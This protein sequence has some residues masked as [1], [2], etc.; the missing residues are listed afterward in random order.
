MDNNDDPKTIMKIIRRLLKVPALPLTLALVLPAP[1][2][3]L[4]QPVDNT[5][6]PE[7]IDRHGQEVLSKL[8]E[9]RFDS[10][11]YSGMP[12][13]EIV[14]RLRAESIKRD[15]DRKGVNFVL[16]PNVPWVARPAP[17]GIDPATG[18]PLAAGALTPSMQLD[19]GSFL[20]SIDPPVTDVRLVDVLDLIVKVA[21]HP[22]T[23]TV[24]DYGVVFS[25]CEPG[26]DLGVETAFS[27][28]GGKPRDLI[29]AVQDYFKVDWESVT[30]LPK[31]MED[32]YIPRFRINNVPGTATGPWSASTISWASN[33]LSWGA[34]LSA[35]T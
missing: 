13:S 24:E 17:V 20:V 33:N 34:W 26:T 25:P 1:L 9:I 14:K 10:V 29:K 23:Y 35:A 15:P 22:I 28:P 4:A 19:I 12:L 3:V 18:L 31:E 8:K 30:D 2:A 27:F 5:K 32:V 11:G 16:N 6:P 7:A 21:D